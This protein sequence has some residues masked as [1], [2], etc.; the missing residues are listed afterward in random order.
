[1][2]AEDKKKEKEESA[3]RYEEYLEQAKKWREDEKKRKEEEDEKAIGDL[4]TWQLKHLI[5]SEI[6]EEAISG[7]SPWLNR[8]QKKT[9]K[10]WLWAV[11]IVVII[12]LG[13]YRMY[14]YDGDYFLSIKHDKLFVQKVFKGILERFEMIQENGKWNVCPIDGSSCGRLL[15]PLE[16]KFNDNYKFVFLTD[17][18]VYWVQNNNIDNK[19]VRLMDGEW[20]FQDEN[21]DEGWTTFEQLK[22]DSIPDN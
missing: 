7:N 8:G 4:K 21:S 19:Q 17:G 6:R 1:M 22:W 9:L 5:R 16:A 12:G 2:N 15:T 3:K 18:S 13:W 20:A 11:A 14:Q 10:R